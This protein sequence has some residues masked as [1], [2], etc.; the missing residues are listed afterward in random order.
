[1]AGL[2]QRRQGCISCCHLAQNEA[3]LALGRLLLLGALGIRH[4]HRC[5]P[6]RRRLR[7]LLLA[8]LL[9]RLHCGLPLAVLGQ[10]L[11]I[12]C[13]TRGHLAACCCRRRTLLDAL[14]PGVNDRGPLPSL[15]LFCVRIGLSFLFF[16]LCA[17]G[18]L[19]QAT[20]SW[21]AWRCLSSGL[22][23]RHRGL[24]RCRPAP[25]RRIPRL[26]SGRGRAR[27]FIRRCV[28]SLGVI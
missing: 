18:A 26:D 7:R 9:S 13:W 19:A 20:Q 24:A 12:D 14:L 6:G 21:P 17:L 11:L 8:L 23:P 1:M 16:A 2:C 25:R 10:A 22:L 28:G 4:C 27:L 15:G 3:L 5:S